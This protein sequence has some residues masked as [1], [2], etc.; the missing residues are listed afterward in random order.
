MRD[1]ST[2]PAYAQRKMFLDKN[3]QVTTQRFED[4]AYPA[5]ADFEEASRGFFWIPKEVNLSKDKLDV[6]L[7][8]PS[9]LFCYTENLLR[10]TT[11]DSLLGRSPSEIFTPVASVPELEKLISAWTFT[12]CNTHSDAYSHIVRM[13][14]NV[15]K[16]VF[17]QI[18][19]NQH[20]VKMAVDIASVFNHLDTL[21]CKRKLAEQGIGTA[22][23]ED[24]HIRAIVLALWC[25]YLTEGI[26]FTVSFVTSMAQVENKKFLG[27]GVIINLIM[28]EENLHARF[29]S[30]ILN[31]LRKTDERF[32]QALSDTQ[33]ERMYMA[34]AVLNEEKLWAAHLFKKG[35]IHGL[36]EKIMVNTAD[37]TYQYRMTDVGESVP[38]VVSSDPVPWMQKYYNASKKIQTA[39]QEKESSQYVIGLLG[40]DWIPDR[41]IKL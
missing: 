16:E 27:S 35:S 8:S 5:L 30:W 4:Y 38:T 28:S 22:P 21:N 40:D 36:N 10:Q 13:V 2:P 3:G 29:V 34:R 15:P 20:I 12:E 23:S 25:A 33:A 6:A 41:M 17:D 14:F 9:E 11:L 18:H 39:L 31:T 32:A 37:W 26:R 19:D 7:A 24:E 1:F